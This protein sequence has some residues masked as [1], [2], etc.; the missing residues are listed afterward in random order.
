[1]RCAFILFNIIDDCYIIYLSSLNIAPKAQLSAI[2]VGI[3]KTR[4]NV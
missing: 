4:F 2:Y 1:M 3:I